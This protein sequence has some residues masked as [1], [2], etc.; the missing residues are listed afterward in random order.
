M[1]IVGFISLIKKDTFDLKK[2]KSNFLL[3]G[4]LLV[5]FS[6]ISASSSIGNFLT[7]YYLGLQKP[8]RNTF[9]SVQEN[10]WRG[11]SS[12]AESVG[13]FYGFVILFSLVLFIYSSNFKFTKIEYLLLLFNIYGLY[14]SNNFAALISLVV[15]ILIFIASSYLVSKQTKLI[16]IFGILI[17]FPL[18]YFIFFNTYSYEDAGRN[19]IQ[20][21]LSISYLENLDTNEWGLN[22]SDQNRYLEIL[23]NEETMNGLS[24][25][26]TYLIEKYHYSERNF[27]PNITTLVSVTASPINRAEKWGTFFGKY[28]PNYLTFL[29]GTG[30]NNI[31]NYYLSHPTK[32]N[33]GL[34]LPHSSIL[35]YLIF[36][37]FLGLSILTTYIILKIYKN[38]HNLIYI[39]FL[40]YF[41]INI[42][43]NDT[44]M[45]LNSFLLFLMVLS[46]DQTLKRSNLKNE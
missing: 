34:I 4:A 13:E 46:F 26:L 5:F 25:S 31:S 39:T 6:L 8:G 32:A 23:K 19:L 1:V 14:K 15:L 18:I 33:D 29:L 44:L 12:S 30:F 37:G 3:S 27:L 35:S 7:Y 11:I 22:A 9:E 24:S 21:G 43:K 16:S 17:L 10:A 38:K 20:Q 42:L 28:N 36:I 41:L 45:Y 2:L 40:S